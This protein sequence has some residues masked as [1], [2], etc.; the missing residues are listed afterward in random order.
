MPFRSANL[1]AEVEGR[2]VVVFWGES[3]WDV[4][5]GEWFAAVNPDGRIMIGRN[6]ENAATSLE[7]QSGD[8]ISIHLQQ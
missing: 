7:C 5:D 2:P 4:N 3:M 6:Y 8:P 1:T